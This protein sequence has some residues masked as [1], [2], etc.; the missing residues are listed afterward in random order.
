MASVSALNFKK[1]LIKFDFFLNIYSNGE[2][3]DGFFPFFGG[4]NRKMRKVVQKNWQR[5]ICGAGVGIASSLF[6]GGGGM[7]AVPLLQKVG[8]T[9]REAHATA[10]L[11]ILPVA[12]L[13]FLFYV[14]K[15]FYDFSVLLPT[16]IGV[17]A[18]GY[19]GA[20]LLGKLPMRQVNWIFIVLQAVAGIFLL[21]R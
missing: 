13:S 12:G 5:M 4:K 1:S 2:D 11:L 8:L 15:G 20:K 21:L 16:A 18:G 10:I 6:G 7:L 17:T 14:W 19:V 3:L 9:G